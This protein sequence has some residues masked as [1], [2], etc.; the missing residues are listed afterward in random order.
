MSKNVAE[1]TCTLNQIKFAKKQ[2]REDLRGTYPVYLGIIPS[3]RYKRRVE[4][5]FVPWKTRSGTLQQKKNPTYQG[6]ISVA[7]KQQCF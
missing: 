4:A 1:P 6:V 2:K 3:V 7:E 5:D